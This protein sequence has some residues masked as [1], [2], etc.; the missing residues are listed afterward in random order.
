VK[1]NKQILAFCCIL[2]LMLVCS[3]S[4]FAGDGDE[5]H[6]ELENSEYTGDAGSDIEDYS[7]FKI[8]PQWN[9][10]STVPDKYVTPDI[11]IKSGV[12]GTINK[13]TTVYYGPSTSYQTRET[14]Y[15][16]K[17]VTVIEK[18][19]SY[20]LIEYSVSG[21]LVRGYVLTT[22]VNGSFGSVPTANN[23]INKFGLNIYG[24]SISVY[25]G[26]ST[27]SYVS[28]GSISNREI[29]TVLK[30]DT[31]SWYHV[32]YWTSTGN[33]RGYVQ[34]QRIS[35]PW[36]TYPYERPIIVGTRGTDYIPPDHVG[37]DIVVASGNNVYAMTSGTAFFYTRYEVEDGVRKMVS[38]GNYVV[39]N[40]GSSR[41]AYY[42]HLSAFMS[43]YSA[44]TYPNTTPPRGGSSK[45]QTLEH[46]SSY[47]STGTYLGKTGNTGFS[48]G[49]HLHFEVREGSTIVD[50]FKYVLFPKMPK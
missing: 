6:W 23:N 26:P 1:N 39:L 29:I 38:Y 42:A 15:S 28:I 25:G 36:F 46:G 30:T 47:V 4:A 21:G 35:V 20:Y 49:A 40:F 45:T 34:T 17:A 3:I 18:E 44:P 2:V 11:S 32:E 9:K 16:G 27:S 43:P 48:T 50:P 24:S 31:S 13:T 12:S 37:I 7:R 14:L 10:A 8:D 19:A 5:Y 22:S 33:K 41:T